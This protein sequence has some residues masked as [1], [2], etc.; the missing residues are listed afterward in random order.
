[1]EQ[2]L[3]VKEE[4]GTLVLIK[5]LAL[6]FL[7]LIYCVKLAIL[8]KYRLVKEISQPKGD[9]QKGIISSLTVNLRP[10]AMESTR[11]VLGNWLEFLVFH[12]GILIAIV[13]SFA[14]PY[15]PQI[16]EPGVVALFM[17]LMGLGFAAGVIRTIKRFTKPE[18]KIISSLDD[19]FSIFMITVFLLLGTISLTGHRESIV[20]FLAVTAFLLVYVPLSKVSH[21]LYWPFARFFM[22]KHFGRRGIYLK[23]G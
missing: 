2:F 21:Y 22:G 7:L 4:F 3:F 6:V 1:M 16:L 9:M 10:S 13:T 11:K 8:M 18:L 12:V 14:I 5:T 17:V 20:I 23:R 15:F 19:Y